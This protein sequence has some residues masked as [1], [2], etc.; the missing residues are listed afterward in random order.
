MMDGNESDLQKAI[1]DIAQAGGA[2][3]ASVAGGVPQGMGDIPPAPAPVFPDAAPMMG[4]MPTAES[5]DATAQYVETNGQNPVAVEPQAPVMPA[6]GPAV[7]GPQSQPEGPE[8]VKGDDYANMD[9]VSVKDR[10]I[11]DLK[12]IIGTVD[13]APILGKVDLLPETK[14][15][16]YKSII[17]TT[18]DKSILGAAYATAKEIASDEGRAEALLY[19]VEMAEKLS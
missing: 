3:G 6:E 2:P 8:V 17:E 13:L 9:T 5:V 1:D 16:I 10:A 14:F 18:R 15:R 19:L 7:V 4:A 11:D 12:P